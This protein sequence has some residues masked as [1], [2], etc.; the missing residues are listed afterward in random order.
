[1]IPDTN[2]TIIEIT[3]MSKIFRVKTQDVLVL[4]KINLQIKS[5]DF[6]VIFGPSGCGKS[7]LLHTMLGLEPPSAGQVH[8]FGLNLYGFE[9]DGRSEFRKNNIGMIYQQPNWIKSLTVLENVAFASSLLGVNKEKYIEQARAVLKVVGMLDWAD[10]LP[11]ELS[12]G[13][14][15]KVSLA[16]ALITNPKVII[17]DEPT[18]NLD[19]QSGRELME[20]FGKLVY[21]GKT[22]IMVT[23][24]IDNVDYANRVIQMFDG[25][26]IGIFDEVAGRID[27]IKRHLTKN[28][29]LK[30]I[31]TTEETNLIHSLT[32]R[33]GLVN[34]R[35][36]K[37]PN[38]FV[39]LRETIKLF[40]ANLSQVANFVGILSLYLL[41]KFFNQ[42]ALFTPR[43]L[44][45][46]LKL[47]KISTTIGRRL[48]QKESK[49]ISKIDLIDLSLKNMLAK[50]T[51]TAITIGGMAVGIGS[52]VFLVSIGYGLERL[53]ISRVARLE[54]MKQ[55]DAIPAVAS[56]VKIT[57]KS[58]SSF[59]DISSVK[60]ILPIIGVV[61]KISYQNSNTDVAVYGVLSDYLKESAIKPAY[62][63]IFSSNELINKLSAEA[64]TVAG[65]STATTA[66]YLQK[67][68]E[69]IFSINPDEFL[70]VRKEPNITSPLIGYTRRV[71][72]IQKAVEYWGGSYLSDDGTGEKGIDEKGGRLGLWLKAKVLLWERK[73]CTN[74]DQGC[75]LNKYLPIKD[76][77]DLPIPQEGYFAEVNLNIEKNQIEEAVLGISTAEGSL[78]TVDIIASLSA[79]S[80]KETVK[81]VSLPPV[82]R[83]EAV[84]NKSLVKVLGIRENIA[85]GKKFSVYFIATGDLVSSENKIVST[86][87][88][89]TIIGVTPDTRTPIVYIP[90]IDLKQLGLNYYSQVKL[91]VNDQNLVAKTRK[92]IE[93]LGFK[94]TSVVDTVAQI[95]RLFFTL[96]LILGLLG[97]VALFVAA[98]GMF[99]TLTISLL[100]RTH[101][102]GMMKA[103][104][105]R[106]VEVQDLFLTES[107]IMG[108]F[109]GLGG[110]FLGIAVGKLASFILSV[111][112]V[113]KGAGF[114][115]ITYIPPIFIVL[116]AFLSIAVGILTGIYPA[117]RATKI[118]ALDALR[119]E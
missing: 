103:I 44:Q 78:S 37:S 3:N 101:E 60:K 32:F 18:G 50:K 92:Q 40:A 55:I 2:K 59:K 56:N 25:Q 81:K 13:Q 9:E 65:A 45:N 109:G 52:I 46:I 71:E 115:D 95:E 74:E 112:A 31:D 105:M 104:G 107:M 89:Y 79:E 10:Y 118:S 30:K 22:V 68:G 20:L 76:D 86:P 77:E 113:I 75:E 33:S 116:I 41:Q 6:A 90:I 72:G 58:L 11:T 108:F 106:S 62:G 54:E 5:G 34:R 100:E 70:R 24:N 38:I 49:S 88:E 51:R 14:Q 85:V 114:I 4:K 26:V 82:E 1:M 96:R 99:N 8:F 119:Y 57:D 48:S 29:S 19:F 87:V 98:L 94:T 80:Q 21:Q 16:R 12:S 61:G 36:K 7:T 73:D 35:I 66:K 17:A 53:V 111:F 67:I 47:D 63:V 39:N 64:G 69:T 91:V 15:Q 42:M 84:I 28:G 93:V 102:V 23:H 97:V 27:N 117:Q 43:F 83:R 110:L